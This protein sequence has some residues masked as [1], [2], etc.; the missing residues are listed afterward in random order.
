M[1][2]CMSMLL[3]YTYW[4][5]ITMKRIHQ[6]FSPHHSL[7]A[8]KYNNFTKEMLALYFYVTLS[9]LQP[10]YYPEEAGFPLGEETTPD[11]YVMEVHYDNPQ[12][13]SGMRDSSGRLLI[14]YFQGFFMEMVVV[15]TKQKVAA[16][17]CIF[18]LNICRFSYDFDTDIKKV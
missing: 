14:L 5:G 7:L 15:Y 8:S 11:Y 10:T 18:A 2:V 16:V 17:I 3:C 13:L 9:N 12:V 1:Y 4:Q 6:V